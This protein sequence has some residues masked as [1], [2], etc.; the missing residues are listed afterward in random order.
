MNLKV[1]SIRY[2]KTNRGVGYQ[3]KTNLK[4]VEIANDGIGGCTY[5]LGK[6]KDIKPFENLSEW[7]LEELLNTYERG[8]GIIC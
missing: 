6:Y 2:F 7:E 4:G 5:L 3:A 8:Q 1:R